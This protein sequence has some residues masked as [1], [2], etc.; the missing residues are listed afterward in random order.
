MNSIQKVPMS[1]SENRVPIF[2]E[3]LKYLNH[4]LKDS[5]ESMMHKTFHRRS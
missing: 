1:S 2:E 5:F 4:I 3:D